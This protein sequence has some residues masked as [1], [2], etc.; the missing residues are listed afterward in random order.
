MNSKDVGNI[1]EIKVMSF[2]IEKG[3]TVSKPFGDNARYD[4][5]VD[6][7]NKLYR[8]QC[9]HGRLENGCI[10]ADASNYSHGDNK[11][12][13]SYVGSADIFGIY[14]DLTN[15]VYLVIIDSDTPT[16]KINLRIEPCKKNYTKKVWWAEEYEADK[17][18]N[19]LLPMPSQC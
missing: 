19:S 18:I 17:I 8:V 14:S 9:K 15:K 7:N 13:E 2:F 3:F 5:I 16:S 11:S 6:I 1:T 12:K 4:L 10:T